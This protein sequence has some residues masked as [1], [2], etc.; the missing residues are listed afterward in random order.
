MAA[1]HTLT[2]ADTVQ[3]NLVTKAQGNFTDI[4]LFLDYSKQAIIDVRLT[5]DSITQSNLTGLSGTGKCL[6]IAGELL[7][8]S[9]A[10]VVTTT[11]NILTSAGADSGAAA[12]ANTTYCVYAS[13][14]LPVFA[15]SDLRLCATAPTDGYLGAAG[16]AQYWRHV[17][18]CRTDA[19]TQFTNVLYVASLFN[20][21]PECLSVLKNETQSV[22]G[23]GYQN[24]T[25]LTKPVLLPPNWLLDAS[26]LME[27]TH[28]VA[29]AAI[30]INLVSGANQYMAAHATAG[31]IITSH[32]RH[33]WVISS[34][35]QVVTIQPRVQ[36][37][38]DTL[39][40]R[41]NSYLKIVR[42]PAP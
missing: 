34:S 26:L 14:S 27:M 31:N 41:P 22:T 29:A 4:Y 30:E 32:I 42:I 36:L 33:P 6:Y 25:V 20:P 16:D 40:I 2:N 3:A 19:S 10:K 15:S 17:G 38:A 8:C 39:T 21:V 37:W 11:D 13:N 9:S 35:L 18:W 12:A 7:N 23:L 1:P 24:I 28:S 5:R